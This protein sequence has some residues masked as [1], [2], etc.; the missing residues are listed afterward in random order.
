VLVE[1]R[2]IVF[3][4]AEADRH[5]EAGPLRRARRARR[6]CARTRTGIAP[7]RSM[8]N[9]RSEGRTRLSGRGQNGPGRSSVEE[10]R[11]GPKG[12]F[13]GERG[14]ASAIAPGNSSTKP[15]AIRGGTR[16]PP[17]QQ[18]TRNP[19]APRGPRTRR[20]DRGFTHT[21]LRPDLGTPAGPPITHPDWSSCQTRLAAPAA[22]RGPPRCADSP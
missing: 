15:A 16:A 18:A 8:V 4:P 11:V 21:M 19:S 6:S 17:D 12:P 3:V 10:D 2:L 9:G 7:T 20:D 13:L 1:K 22:S 5:V 14:V